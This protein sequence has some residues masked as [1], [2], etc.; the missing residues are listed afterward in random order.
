MSGGA[1]SDQR[2]V[3]LLP[4][5]RAPTF[6]TPA[7]SG[8]GL[9]TFLLYLV[10]AVAAMVAWTALIAAFALIKDGKLYD[11]HLASVDQSVDRDTRW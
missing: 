2:R 5:T 7:G 10:S 3:W 4:C 1:A 11:E 9:R 8:P 6:T